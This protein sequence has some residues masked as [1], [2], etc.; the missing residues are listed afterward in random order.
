MKPLLAFERRLLLLGALLAALSPAFGSARS[1][2]VQ[3]SNDLG[4][5]RSVPVNL[6][7]TLRLS[8]RHSIYGS[9]VEEVFSLRPGG[10]QL[11]QLR[12][13]EARLVEF[14]GHESASRD[15]NAWVVTPAPIHLSRLDLKSSSNGAMSVQFDKSTFAKPLMIPPAGALR[16]TVADCN[17]S[18]NG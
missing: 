10:F 1:F 9:Q 14:Y 17:R 3:L 4:F 6:G 13:G 16:L 11:T 8:F 7:G 2:C 18:A 15:N 5:E 12:Y